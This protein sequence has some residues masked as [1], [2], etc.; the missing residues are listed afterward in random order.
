MGHKEGEGIISNSNINNIKKGKAWG[1]AHTGGILVLKSCF[2]FIY[3]A[4]SKGT[5]TKYETIK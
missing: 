2:T 1:H 3:F 4:F 5:V